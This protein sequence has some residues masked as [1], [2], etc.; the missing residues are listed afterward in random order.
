M[1]SINDYHIQGEKNSVLTDL[2]EITFDDFRKI[3]VTSIKETRKRLKNKGSFERIT[4]DTVETI[5]YGKK[6]KVVGYLQDGKLMAKTLINDTTDSILNWGPLTPAR[7]DQNIREIQVNGPVIFVDG[8]QGYRVLRDEYGKPIVFQTPEDEYNFL[9]SLL[10]FSGERMTEDEPFVNALTK[11]GFRISCAHPCVHPPHHTTP[12]L[13]WPQ[14]TIRKIG[15]VELDI[16]DL[17]MYH[18]ATKEM[19]DWEILLPQAL[20]GGAVVGTTG[21]GKTTIVGLRMRHVRNEDR[22]FAIQAPSE[23][24]YRNIVDGLMVNNAVYIEVNPKADTNKPYSATF[25]HAVDHSLRNTA[26]MLMLGELRK[27]DEFVAGARAYNAG[28][29][30]TATFHTMT[31]SGAVD[32]FALELVSGLGIDMDVARELA[33][34]YI[35]TITLCDRLGDQSRK[36]MAQAEVEGFDRA[37]KSYKINILTEFVLVATIKDPGPDGEYGKLINIGYF[38][39]RM[40]PSFSFKQRLLKKVATEDMDFFFNI[41]DGQVLEE[42]NFE[43]LPDDFTVEYSGELI[44]PKGTKHH[45]KCIDVVDTV[46]EVV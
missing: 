11:E 28:T 31:I 40:N 5:V 37:T 16:P 21:C 35:P 29:E 30:V 36:I 9:E 8:K 4:I 13:K 7:N 15:D 23:Y 22:V 3:V 33:C 43:Y 18:T 10:L 24:N 41:P 12:N 42:V 19:L 17:L 26:S 32:R 25:G 39:K 20:I 46:G 1:I 2:S 44:P 34:S 45:Y 38:I 27:A 14:A 6:P